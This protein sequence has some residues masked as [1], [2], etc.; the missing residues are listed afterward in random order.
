MISRGR[1]ILGLLGMPTVVKT[2]ASNEKI[3]P[4]NIFLDKMFIAGFTYYDGENTIEDL[5]Q[6]DQLFLKLEP[7]NPYDKRAIEIYTKSGMKLG[8]IPRDRNRIPYHLLGQHIALEARI[9]KISPDEADW[10]KV[11][12]S[13]S[14]VPHND[15]ARSR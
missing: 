13:L 12:I 10:R 11:L 7:D 3:I 8:Y 6:G 5:R 15:P 14:Q 4:Q 1:F 2:I 9:D